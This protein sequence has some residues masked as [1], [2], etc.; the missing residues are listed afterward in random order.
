MLNLS[1]F[2]VRG[3]AV[4][5]TASDYAT[6]SG[7]SLQD[8]RKGLAKL[9]RAGFVKRGERCGKPVFRLAVGFD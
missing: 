6:R 8:A 3:K 2:V 1:A 9:I 4:D 5:L 7:I